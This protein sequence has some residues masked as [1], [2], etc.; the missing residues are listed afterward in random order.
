MTSL[1]QYIAAL[2][3]V[4]G[5]EHPAAL[6]RLRNVVAGLRAR[7]ILDEESVDISFPPDGLRVEPASD[8]TPVDGWGATDSATV[9]AL[10]DGVI[11]VGDAIL[12]GRLRV[13]GPL[14][15]ISQMFLAIEI[16]LDASSQTPG[17]QALA[18]LFRAEKAEHGW[19]KAPGVERPLWYPFPGT[20]RERE[21]LSRLDLLPD[22]PGQ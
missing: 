6:A 17:L 19:I 18:D 16:I 7:I 10:L 15:E 4:L 5:A 12:D 20:A 3:R 13:T 22:G 1:G 9:L 14:Q 2:I 11:E 8:I 21:L